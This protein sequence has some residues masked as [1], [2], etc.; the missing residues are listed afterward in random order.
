MIISRTGTLRLLRIIGVFCALT[1]GFLTLVGTSEDDATNALGIDDSVEEDADV[2]LD[3]VTV[4]KTSGIESL[5][6][7][8]NCNTLS[9]NDALESVKDQIE[10][11]DNIDIDSVKLQY[12]QGTYTNANWTPVDIT[13][14]T[15]SLTISGSQP[16]IT[17]AETAVNKGSGDLTVEELTTEQREAINHYLANRNETFTYCVEC[18]EGEDSFDTYS[19]TYNVEIGVTIKGDVDVF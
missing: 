13:S 10:D 9:I 2:Q 7:G 14:L 1:M 12:V 11:F 8:D 17:I 18:S 16:T 3:P 5:A 15:C 6:A 19:V 4:E